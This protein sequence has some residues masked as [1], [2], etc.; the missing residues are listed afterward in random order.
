MKQATD[1]SLVCV[2]NLEEEFTLSPHVHTPRGITPLRLFA[3]RNQVIPLSRRDTLDHLA[4][5]MVVA[6]TLLTFKLESSEGT[7]LYIPQRVLRDLAIFRGSV[8]LGG[9][10]ESSSDGRGGT[11]HRG[12]QELDRSCSSLLQGGST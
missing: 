5:A 2:I 6:P 12:R 7:A 9:H 11:I 4:M 1:K 10:C 3:E 8:D